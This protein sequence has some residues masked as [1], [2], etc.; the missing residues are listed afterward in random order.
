MNEEIKRLIC[1]N[2]AEIVALSQELFHLAEAAEEEWQSARAIAGYLEQ[3]GFEVERG[4]GHMPTALRA[5]RGQGGPVI[6]FLGEYDALPGLDQPPKPDY[7]GDP[8]KNGHGCGHNLL[9]AG[10]AVYY[11]CPAE[12]T[13]KGKTVML[14]NGCF[15]ELDAAL[16][17]QPGVD[18]NC[19]EL[20][21][22][23]M[24]SIRFAFEGTSAHAS[25][26][27]HRGRSALDACELMNVGVNYLREHIPD[28]VRI[29]YSYLP[30]GESAPNIVPAHAGLWY[31]IR[32]R[33]RETVD[34]VTARV[35]EIARGAALMTSTKVEWEFLSRGYD[36]LVNFGMC[37]LI[38]RVMEE[39]GPPRFSSE[40]QA[41]VRGLAGHL[42]GETE[43]IRMSETLVRPQ[44][45]VAYMSGST[46]VSDVS[47]V[48]PV[49]YFRTVCGPMGC[50]LHSWQYTACAGHSVGQRGMLFAAQVL[51][52]TGWRL[53]RSPSLL[54]E[55]RAE[56][57]ENAKPYCPLL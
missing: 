20:A 48:V 38:H 14:K 5:V 22:L 42:E 10:T 23:A 16:S 21:Y 50:P 39:I 36:T 12:E 40:E 26:A 2:Q 49:G 57:T 55:I 8:Q 41:F 28:D 18:H 46:D 30:G 53:M 17:F 34:D 6:G 32:A 45:A 13:L 27:P 37:R 54:R 4:V 51:A 56:F 19:G 15:T 1:Q 31:F 29:H 3:R 35:E 9:G 11:G 33:K 43:E 52:E 44:G 24:D 25:A 7:C 47:R